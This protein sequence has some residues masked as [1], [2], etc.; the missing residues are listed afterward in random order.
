MLEAVDED[1]DDIQLHPSFNLEC[2]AKEYWVKHRA[3]WKSQ[4][5]DA[6]KE[7]E[8]VHAG[9]DDIYR[10]IMYEGFLEGVRQG[11]TTIFVQD[12]DIA[13]QVRQLNAE[14]DIVHRGL[15]VAYS[16]LFE[17]YSRKSVALASLSLLK[18]QQLIDRYGPYAKN[19]KLFHDTS[20]S[21]DDVT[22]AEFIERRC[23]DLKN[24]VAAGHAPRFVYCGRLTPRKG[25]LD[26]VDIVAKCH[27]MG[28]PIE[29]DII[30][31]GEQYE[32]IEARIEKKG[33]GSAIKMLGRMNYGPELF[34]KLQTYD[35]LLFTP[36]A[37]D[38]PRMI[39][40]GYAAGL[41]LIAYEIDYCIERHK[42]ESATWLM[43]LKN[44]DGAANR[45][46]ELAK[47]P[48]RLCELAKAAH[49]AAIYHA[50][51]NWYRRRAEWTFEAHEKFG[52]SRSSNLMTASV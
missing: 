7:S 9:L 39:F 20:Y 45:L 47:N 34:K 22:D 49:E 16:K 25:I 10:P 35:G 12:T 52:S 31:H 29:F 4:L 15:S 1:A 8:V 40:D 14:R 38:T 17:R 41:P 24:R 46:T 48:D 13:V 50:A 51:E 32:E 26:S 30:G 5:H 36:L 43:P 3:M 27:Q 2:G 42:T 28:A 19:A 37:E 44:V 11:K 18:G 21:I 6:V 23:N 33:M